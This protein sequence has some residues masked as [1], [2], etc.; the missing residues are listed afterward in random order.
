MMDLKEEYLVIRCTWEN[1]RKLEWLES[2]DYPWTLTPD[3]ESTADEG[4]EQGS[5]LLEESVESMVTQG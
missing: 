3:P 5:L 1:E 2:L 4:E